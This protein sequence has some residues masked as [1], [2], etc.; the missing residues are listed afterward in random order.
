MICS[1]LGPRSLKLRASGIVRLRWQ[2]VSAL[3]L[4]RIDRTLERSKNSVFGLRISGKETTRSGLGCSILGRRRSMNCWTQLSAALG[5]RTRASLRA[6]SEKV[7]AKEK[8]VLIGSN[9]L[10]SKSKL[11]EARRR[12]E[13]CPASQQRPL[14]SPSF[15]LVQ[16][17]TVRR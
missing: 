10:G 7:E 4:F 15:R 14:T 13:L 3:R 6:C 8:S 2:P 17:S 5:P 12:P 11:T 16:C 9:Q 1:P